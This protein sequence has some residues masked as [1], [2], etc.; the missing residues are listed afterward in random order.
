MSIRDIVTVKVS[1]ADL[2]RSIAFYEKL[3]LAA[4]R[5]TSEADADWFRDL[6]GVKTGVRAQ[7]ME[8]PDNPRAMSVE[9]LEWR[10]KGQGAG[11]I[12]APGAGMFAV[13]TDDIDADVEMLRQGG[14]SVVSAPI[15]LQGGGMKLATVRDPDGYHIQLMQ[16]VRAAAS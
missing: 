1:C 10:E 6:Y 15:T 13:R 2:A 16:F 5:P 7:L 11:D 14:G 8:R 3:G 12:T 4:V 9:L